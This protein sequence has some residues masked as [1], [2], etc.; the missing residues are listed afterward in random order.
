[1]VQ[2]HEK[3][4]IISKTWLAVI[5]SV[6]SALILSA[7]GTAWSANATVSVLRSDVADIKNAQL[8]PRVTVMEQ[9]LSRVEVRQT[10][11]EDKLDR[12]LALAISDRD[13]DRP[14]PR[15]GDR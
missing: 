5:V 12:V 14:T 6:T 7:I 11:M 8:N 4:V 15:S 2:Y 13:R 9:T 1:M 10:R 3:A